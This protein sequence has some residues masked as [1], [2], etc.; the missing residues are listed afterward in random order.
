MGVAGGSVVKTLP[1]DAGDTGWIPDPGRSQAEEQ[2][3]LMTTAEPL[4]WSPGV[5][6]TEAAR[7]NCGAQTATEAHVPEPQLRKE[8]SR[9]KEKP[10]HRN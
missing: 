10:V 6:T 3:S 4:L 8:R 9:V 2:L 5:A 7:C 1:A